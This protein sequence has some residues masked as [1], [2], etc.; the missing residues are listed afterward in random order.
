MTFCDQLNDSQIAND[1]C[2]C[3]EVYLNIAIVIAILKISIQCRSKLQIKLDF[4]SAWCFWKSV[5]SKLNNLK[6]ERKPA[7]VAW[8]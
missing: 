2:A 5:F 3:R 7:M 6:C 1:S 4:F 8:G